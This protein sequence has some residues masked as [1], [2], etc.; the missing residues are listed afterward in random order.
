MRTPRPS[1]LRALFTA[2][3]AAAAL[4]AVGCFAYAHY[5]IKQVEAGTPGK[6]LR[7]AVAAPCEPAVFIDSVTGCIV[8]RVSTM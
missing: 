8:E 5:T 7:R 4:T 3:A 6:A 1:V 2:V